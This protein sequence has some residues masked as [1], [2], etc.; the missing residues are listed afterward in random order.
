M[1]YELSKQQDKRGFFAV[2]AALHGMGLKPP[3]QSWSI[4]CASLLQSRECQIYERLGS[5]C[6]RSADRLVHRAVG[7]VSQSIL[8]DLRKRVFRQTQRLSL[9]LPR[10]LHLRAHHLPA[11][12]RPGLD[13]RAAGFRHHRAGAGRPVHGVHR[14]RP[15]HAGRD[16]RVHPVPL[17]DPARVPHPLVPG[18]V[19]A[20]VPQVAGGVGAAHRA[21]RRDHDGH[22]RGQGVPQGEAQRARV[23]RPRRGLPGHQQQG[24]PAVRILRS[25]AGADRQRHAAPWCS[26]WADSASPAVA[27]AIGVLLGHPA[28]HA[29]VLRSGAGDGDVLQLATS[30]PRRRSRRSP[31]CSRSGRAFRTRPARSTCGRR[32]ARIGFEGVEFAYKAGRIILPRFDLRAFRP[33]RP[34]RWSA[35]PGRASRR[36]RS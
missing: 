31:G 26:W 22:P 29:A 4:W 13:P 8:L 34:S 12:Q 15:D 32:R 36:W 23:R 25:G 27:L 2:M 1:S 6:R 30:R 35:R 5:D 3:S 20:A 14:D 18:A 33:G 7:Q 10:E 24:H 19:A 28:V 9:E 21:V 11:D 16:E 17:A